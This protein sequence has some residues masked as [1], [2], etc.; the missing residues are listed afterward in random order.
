MPAPVYTKQNFVDN[1]I[2]SAKHLDQIEEQIYEMSKEPNVFTQVDEPE[3]AVEG[4]V[5][6]IPTPLTE[7][8]YPIE[9]PPYSKDD[10]GKFLMATAEG[11]IWMPL[12]KEYRYVEEGDA[13]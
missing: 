6:I 3:D 9:L 10:Y 8:G 5:W 2:L 4:D 13:F 1:E 11:L 12:N 7:E